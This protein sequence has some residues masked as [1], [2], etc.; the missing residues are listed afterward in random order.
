MDSSAG[1]RSVSLQH[2]QALAL[3][4]SR[5]GVVARRPAC[6]CRTRGQAMMARLAPATLPDHTPTVL[7]PMTLG[8]R[9]H[10]CPGAQ[11]GPKDCLPQCGNKRLCRLGVTPS[12]ST[13]GS[14]ILEAPLCLYAAWL[15][16]EITHA[17]YSRLFP[18]WCKG[19]FGHV[20]WGD[21]RWSMRR[22]SLPCERRHASLGLMGYALTMSWHAGALSVGL[23]SYTLAERKA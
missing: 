22:S 8:R 7:K 1:V 12:I 18:H 2:D 10:G 23:S 4:W 6:T 9:H 5:A 13:P 11:T 15:L 20:C 19:C 21:R 14:H 16:I 17:G 3:R